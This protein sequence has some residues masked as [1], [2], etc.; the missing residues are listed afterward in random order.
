MSISRRTK[1]TAVAAS[2]LLALAACSSGTDN[3]GG[4][5]TDAPAT[6]SGTPVTIEY[7]HRL[8]DGEGMTLVNDIVARWN[9]EH[10]DIQVK[11]TKFDG[12][13]AD[14]NAKVKTDIDN[15]VAPCLFQAGYADLAGLYVDGTVQDVT[16]F[17]KQYAD[18]FGEGPFN[19]MA[20][21]GKFFGLP[22]DTGPLVYFYDKAEFEALGLT[23]PTTAAEFVETAKAA[24]EKG[25]Y[26]VS[27][28][29]DEASQIFSAMTAAAGGQWFGIDG[30]SWTVNVADKGSSAIQKFWQDLL[31]ADAVAVV[32]RW[33][34]DWGPL[35]NDNKLIG[36]IG[37]AW[38]APLLQGDMAGSDNEGN[39]AIAQLP[40]FGDGAAS[41][42]DGGSGVVVSKTCEF[43]QQA[44]EFNAWFNTQVN[45]LASQGLVVAAT[46]Q[47][48][49]PAYAAFYGGQDVLAEFTKA[50][51]AMNAFTFIP[52]WAS[53]MT[54]LNTDSAG[55]GDGSKTVSDVF[56]AGAETAKQA[57]TNAG[58][59]V[60][61]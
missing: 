14:L 6:D 37:A 32:G 28:Q 54:T 1:A 33:T 41:G 12:A 60:A 15:G 4:T 10:P 25:K 21:D 2:T 30:D 58:L 45:D 40:D 19:S 7:L 8:P 49:A 38:E 55:A 52:G 59:K 44:M 24:A 56:M 57:L 3:A 9:E 26:I 5:S 39:W 17:A 20:V 50:N 27:Y 22:Q 11:A 34:E 35:L 61:E 23:V 13:P 46:E 48:S 31:D 18:K 42:P 36:T 43:P 29:P 47:P 16:E 53:V 51:D